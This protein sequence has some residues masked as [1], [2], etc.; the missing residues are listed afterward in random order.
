MG[1]QYQQESQRRYRVNSNRKT[2]STASSQVTVR[3]PTKDGPHA[4]A[5]TLATSGMPTTLGM[6]PKAGRQQQKERQQQKRKIQKFA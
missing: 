1:V 2:S 4:T 6:L 5:G 3:T